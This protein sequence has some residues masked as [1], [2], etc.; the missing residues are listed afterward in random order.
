MTIGMDDPSMSAQLQAAARAAGS[1]GTTEFTSP[2]HDSLVPPG[3]GRVDI[4]L[5]AAAGDDPFGGAPTVHLSPPLAGD[6][7]AE[8]DPFDAPTASEPSAEPET[9]D[10]RPA[11]TPSTARSP[12][13]GRELVGTLLLGG[14]GVAG[15]YQG[16]VL[17]G[18]DT[19]AMMAVGAAA[20][21]LLGWSWI[22]W[23]A[24]RHC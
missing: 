20:G 3:D 7:P 8:V 21:L 22:R 5:P 18:T 6:G 13:A 2:V 16:S 11:G 4:D 23:V 19:M 15:G 17:T 24:R 10:A 1:A 9:A 12:R 14:L